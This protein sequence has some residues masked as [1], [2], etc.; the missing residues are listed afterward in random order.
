MIVRVLGTFF[1]N[2]IKCKAHRIENINIF[3][4]L[5]PLVVGLLGVVFGWLD[6]GR[7]WVGGL[8]RFLLLDSLL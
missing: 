1:I 5:G 8:M 4:L 7:P 2:E 3:M 6:V